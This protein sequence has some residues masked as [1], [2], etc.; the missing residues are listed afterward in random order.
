MA[1]LATFT[2]WANPGTVAW[3]GMSSTDNEVRS[4]GRLRDE[5]KVS[6]ARDSEGRIFASNV[7]RDQ[8]TTTWDVTPKSAT[9]LADAKALIALPSPGALVTIAGIG[10]NIFDGVW[11]YVGGGEIVLGQSDEEAIVISGLTLRRVSTDGSTVA[12]Q[13]VMS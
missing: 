12:A 4:G 8:Q 7:T 9:S 3:S 13:T 6:D 10:N 11:N 5:I 1:L 2:L